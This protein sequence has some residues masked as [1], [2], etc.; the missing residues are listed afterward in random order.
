[1]KLRLLVF[2]LTLSAAVATAQTEKATLRGTV[3]D[4]SNLIVPGA[5][6]VV[7]DLATN[8]EARRLISDSNG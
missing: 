7:T 5:E 6:I 8:V 1:M 3:T 2:F 4:P